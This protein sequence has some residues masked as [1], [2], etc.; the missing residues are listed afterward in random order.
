MKEEDDWGCLRPLTEGGRLG[1]A[2]PW[3]RTMSNKESVVHEYKVKLLYVTGGGGNVCVP[4]QGAKNNSRAKPNFR[5]VR[6]DQGII[7]RFTNGS[8]KHQ[9]V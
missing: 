5:N 6:L 3:C 9:R 1:G 7:C 2:C 8:P 4:E